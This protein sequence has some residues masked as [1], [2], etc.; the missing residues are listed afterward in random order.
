VEGQPAPGEQL[1]LHSGTALIVVERR[2]ALPIGR[3]RWAPHSSEH[4]GSCRAT[5]CSKRSKP[6]EVARNMLAVV[7]RYVATIEA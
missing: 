6:G 7:E 3:P 1:G 5:V 4:R 2:F